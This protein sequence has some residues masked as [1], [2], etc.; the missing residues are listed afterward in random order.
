MIEQAMKM[1]IRDIED[2]SD[3]RA[4]RSAQR[5]AEERARRRRR[6]LSAHA[7]I[8]GT[9]LAATIVVGLMYLNMIW[10]SS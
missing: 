9:L 7:V 5:R 2:W 4:E 3:L 6:L 1:S 8:V 10:P